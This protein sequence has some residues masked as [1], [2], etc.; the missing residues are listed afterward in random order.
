MFN[1]VLPDQNR[2]IKYRKVI[3]TCSSG[4][5]LSIHK[6]LLVS[7]SLLSLLPSQRRNGTPRPRSV[8][9]CAELKCKTGHWSPGGT[10]ERTKQK[11]SWEP[12]PYP[13]G[14]GSG[15]QREFEKLLEKPVC[16]E[17]SV[18]CLFFSW[19]GTSGAKGKTLL[20]ENVWKMK[21]QRNQSTQGICS[22]QWEWRDLHIQREA[23]GKELQRD[24][25]NPWL[26]EGGWL[27]E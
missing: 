27:P 25:A 22:S 24:Y 11:L 6:F 19:K 12:E 18:W 4:G 14:M 2:L 8:C 26:G 1:S 21:Q 13:G 23:A 10:T 9:Y 20:L 17:V 7:C 15:I 3:K 5:D 16:V